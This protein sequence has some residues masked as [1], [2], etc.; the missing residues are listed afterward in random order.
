MI[1]EGLVERARKGRPPAWIARRHSKSPFSQRK[2]GPQR[3][4]ALIDSR[5]HTDPPPTI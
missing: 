4:R 5:I 2:A 1:I 3:S